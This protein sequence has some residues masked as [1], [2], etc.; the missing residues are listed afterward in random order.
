MLFCFA[1]AAALV[2]MTCGM[3]IYR[4][5]LSD[6]V[7]LRKNNAACGLFSAKKETKNEVGDWQSI[8]GYDHKK[9]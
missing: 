7:T 8:I 1:S 3:L 9:Q 5:G 4:L 2:F 6:G